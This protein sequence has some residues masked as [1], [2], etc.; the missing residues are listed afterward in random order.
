MEQQHLANP[1]S[2]QEIDVCFLPPHGPI[3]F[4]PSYRPVENVLCVFPAVQPLQGTEI[5]SPIT[6]GVI[7]ERLIPL[8]EHVEAWRNLHNISPWVLRKVEKGYRIQF[9]YRPPKYNGVVNTVVSHEQARVMDMEVQYLLVKEAIEMFPPH[10]RETRFYSQYSIVP[11]K[12]SLSLTIKQ[13]RGLVCHNRSKRCVF[14]YIH[15]SPTQE[16]PEVRFSREKL[17]NKLCFWG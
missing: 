6:P 9:E 16:I 11:K 4:T 14:P 10:E 2:P 15:P 5:T 13:I 17:T 12:E 1:W 7:L 3:E 8:L